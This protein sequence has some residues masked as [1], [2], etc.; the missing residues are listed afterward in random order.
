MQ[1]R[2]R[3]VLLQDTTAIPTLSSTRWPRLTAVSTPQQGTYLPR[4]RAKYHVGPGCH[5]C[6]PSQSAARTCVISQLHTP[7]KAIDCSGVHFSPRYTL[8]GH[9]SPRH[10]LVGFSVFSHQ[11][12]VLFDE[13]IRPRRR[14]CV[15]LS[16]CVCAKRCYEMIKPKKL[17]VSPQIITN[18]CCRLGRHTCV[19]T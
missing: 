16:L 19:S 5:G 1:C 15:A 9:F 7:T 12:A 11:F 4:V 17:T 14:R 2:G 13:P 3:S 6:F 10:T 18:D 8:V